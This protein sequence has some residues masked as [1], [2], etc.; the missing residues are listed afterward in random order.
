MPAIAAMARRHQPGLLVVDRAVGGRYENYRTPEQE[1]PG[2][3]LPYIWETC[4]TMGTSWSYVP[5]DTYKPARTLIH[6]LS[7]V[8]AKGGNFLLN[9]GPSPDGELPSVALQRLKEIGDWMSVNGSAIYATRPASPYSEG[10]LRFTRGAS[11]IVNVVYLASE[12]ETAP[13][14]RIRLS[15]FTPEPGSRVTMLGVKEP[16]V[17]R[18]EG[19]T[20]TIVIPASVQSHPPCAHAWT[21]RIEMPA[22]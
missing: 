21:V 16:L 10:P 12:R 6:L 19:S 17:W 9:I 5:T 7:D 8:V 14:P 15:A 11:G 13:P 2:A 20:T 3:P 22:H 18:K 4:M 1:I